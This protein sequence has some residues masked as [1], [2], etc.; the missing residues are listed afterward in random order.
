MSSPSINK[1]FVT[2]ALHRHHYILNNLT[3]LSTRLYYIQWRLSPSLWDYTAGTICT[4]D[5]TYSKG[6]VEEHT[7]IPTDSID[8][9]LLLWKQLL[10]SHHHSLDSVRLSR[11]CTSVWLTRHLQHSTLPTRDTYACRYTQSVTHALYHSRMIYQCP[12]QTLKLRQ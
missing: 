12:I 7:H 2:Y 1:S 6:L 11:G 9:V 5:G 10:G 4:P 8:I 3:D